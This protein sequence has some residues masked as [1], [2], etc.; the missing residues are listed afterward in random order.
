MKK[1]LLIIKLGAA[2]DVV[3]TSVVLHLFKFKKVD[4]LTLPPHQQLLPQQYP[5][6]SFVTPEQA[7]KNHYRLVLSLDEEETIMEL[8]PQLAKDQ[9]IGVFK[10]NGRY[11]YTEELAPW[12]DMSL[13]SRYGRQRADELKWENRRSYQS[14]LFE[15]LGYKFQKEPYLINEQVRW[16]P[17]PKRIGIE[18]RAG[19]RWPTKRWN[20]FP[21]LIQYLQQQGFEPF[22]FQKRPTLLQYLQ[23]IASCEFLI[24]GDSLCMHIGLALKIPMLTFFT[25]TS[26]WEIEDYGVMKK[27]VSPL[28]EKAFYK[29]TYMKEVLDAI[30]LSHVIE[31]FHEH[32]KKFYPES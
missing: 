17:I 25:C 2:G 4:W 20:Q 27:I 9:L 8:L 14:F 19:E 5:Y 15:A 16:K 28:L 31:Q 18:T 32:Y 30:P 13:V 1:D 7:L 11:Y 23:D 10:E 26:P 22:V 3:R 21:Q 6:L 24:T 12:F 29:T